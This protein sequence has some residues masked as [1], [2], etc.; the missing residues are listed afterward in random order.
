M[1][2]RS[3]TCLLIFTKNF[4]ELSSTSS[5][6]SSSVVLCTDVVPFYL[7]PQLYYALPIFHSTFFLNLIMHCLCSILPPTSVVLCTANVP[8]YLLPQL[9]YALPIFHSTFFLNL[10]M[11]CLCSILP[12]TSVVL[13]T[14]NV[15]FYLLPH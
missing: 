11:H 8:F 9:Y 2:C 4:Q 3:S 5:L 12:P 7:L 6:P 1:H 13:C 10:I 15:L 14:A